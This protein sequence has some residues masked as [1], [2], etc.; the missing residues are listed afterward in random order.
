MSPVGRRPGNPDTRAE[1][2]TAARAAFAEAGYDRATIRDIASRADVDPSLVH[3]YFGTKEELYASSIA[4]P[5]VPVEVI[6]AVLSGPHEDLGRRL[7]GAFFGI[8]ELDGPR[9]ALLGMLRGAL[10]GD[11]TAMRAF[12]EFVVTTIRDRLAAEMVGDDAQLRAVGIASQL[13]G[14]AV[15]RHVARIEPVASATTEEL[16]DLVAP[17]LQSYLDA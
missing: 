15:V 16:V 5:V 7:A 4:L 3:H 9:Q 2:L 13:V 12:R 14:V 11:D 10:G 17:R 6:G 8:W 1:I